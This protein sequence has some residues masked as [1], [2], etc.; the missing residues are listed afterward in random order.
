MLCAAKEDDQHNENREEEE[1]SNVIKQWAMVSIPF[2]SAPLSVH[3]LP[4]YYHLCQ[5]V[6]IE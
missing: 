3:A 2:H 6:K 4:Y 5:N 1:E